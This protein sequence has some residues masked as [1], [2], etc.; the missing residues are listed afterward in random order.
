MGQTARQLAA[1][2][3]LVTAAAF[4]P[5]GRLVAVGYRDGCIVALNW[6]SERVI[7]LRAPDGEPIRETLWGPAGAWFA[8][9]AGESVAGIIATGQWLHDRL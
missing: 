3:S 8:F 6:A 1:R 7:V 4:H 9:A 2:E 5:K